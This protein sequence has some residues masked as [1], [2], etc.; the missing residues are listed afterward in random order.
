MI[1]H[2]TFVE[3]K[4][5]NLLKEEGKMKVKRLNGK[6]VY[7]TIKPIDWNA[8]S[9]SNFQFE[10][11]QVLRGYWSGDS[12]GEEVKIPE[13]LLYCD[14]VNLTRKIIIEVNGAQHYAYNKFFHRKNVFNFV[15]N[16]E[17]DEKKRLFAQKNNFAFFEVKTVNELRLILISL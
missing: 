11:K 14:F 2:V 9:K 3:K 16:K 17:R 13:A 1:V 7:W 15:Y 12:V 8:K 5:K 6:E 4:E 10:C